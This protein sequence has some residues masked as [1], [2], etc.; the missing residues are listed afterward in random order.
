MTIKLKTTSTT[1]C[2]RCVRVRKGLFTIFTLS[3]LSNAVIFYALGLG[4]KTVFQI[5]TGPLVTTAAFACI[6]AIKQ[7][8]EKTHRPKL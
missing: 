5:L 4:P 2:Q 8:Y 1:K 7:H 6:F 3:L